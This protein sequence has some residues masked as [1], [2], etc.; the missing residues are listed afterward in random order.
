MGHLEKVPL[1]NL[2]E[3]SLDAQNTSKCIKPPTQQPGLVIPKMIHPQDH[4]EVVVA[5]PAVSFFC[6]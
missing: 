4:T 2:M 6:C 3:V 1:K 5:L